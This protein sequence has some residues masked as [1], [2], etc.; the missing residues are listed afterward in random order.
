[1]NKYDELVLSS[2]LY[3]C[4]DQELLKYQRT[5]VNYLDKYN[6]TLE[7]DEGIKERQEILKNACGTYGENLFIL[8]PIHANFGLK[9]VHFGK[10][11][12]INFNSTF[13]DDGEITIGDDVMVGPNVSFITA[14]HPISPRLRKKKLQ[15]NKPIRIGTN[16]WIG[17]NVVILPGVTIGDNSVIGAG[18]VVTKDV[19]SN[20]VVV[21]NPSKILRE[22]TKEDDLYF[23]KKKIPE[24]ILEKYL[25]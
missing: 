22:I 24:D 15:Y 9:H 2:S 14:S 6:H 4:D 5:L 3:D 1:M 17:S 18:A 16:V 19:P 21:G 10:N 20:V 7:T 11:V 8:P 23:D 13:V 12:F 25:K